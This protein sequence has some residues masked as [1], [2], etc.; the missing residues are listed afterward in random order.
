MQAWLEWNGRRLPL[1]DSLTIGRHRDNVLVLDDKKVSRRH[2][3]VYQ[4]GEEQFWVVDL[5]SSNGTRRNGQ[6]L[7]QSALL[8]DGDRLELG[9]HLLH[10]RQPGVAHPDLVGTASESATAQQTNAA[11]ASTVGVVLIGLRGE[12]LRITE[13]A[14]EL[15]RA[16]FDAPPGI[17]GL[18][19]ELQQWVHENL[20]ASRPATSAEPTF[21]LSAARG[22]LKVRFADRGASELLLLISEEIPLTRTDALQRLGLSGRECEVAHWLAEGKTNPEIAL[23]LGLSARTVEKHV[24]HILAKLDVPNRTHAL[25]HIVEHLGTR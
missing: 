5:G 4:Q 22:Q 23:I 13:R 20:P 11:T 2:A 17:A 25:R 3:L 1:G 18:P 10:F 24:E 12:L 14:A 9:A 8:T 16:Y 6:V 15:L 7:R 21:V 19:A